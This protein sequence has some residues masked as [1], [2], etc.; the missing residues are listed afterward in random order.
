[1]TSRGLAIDVDERDDLRLLQTEPGLGRRT[2]ELLESVAFS[3][4][5]R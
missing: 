2:S 1:V 5:I 4:A 3:A